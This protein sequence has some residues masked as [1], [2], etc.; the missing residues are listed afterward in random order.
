MGPAK[1]HPNYLFSIN[2]SEWYWWYQ[3]NLHCG[4][5]RLLSKRYFCS[6]I[7]NYVL[8]STRSNI[9]QM[10]LVYSMYVQIGYC[11]RMTLNTWVTLFIGFVPVI[12]YHKWNQQ[13]PDH[14]GRS[15]HWHHMIL[16]KY[17][18]CPAEYH[19]T[20]TLLQWSVDILTAWPYLLWLGC[21][22]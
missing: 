8:H 20:L 16:T 18:V 2:M 15:L 22:M 14:L 5:F 7:I 3:T 11:I 12:L 13:L 6:C 21:D 1:A 10:Y 4:Q 9:C 17:H 19:K